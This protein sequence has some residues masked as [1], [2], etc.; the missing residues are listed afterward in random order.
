MKLTKA[1][2]R[3]LGNILA[4]GGTSFVS[5]GA[6]RVGSLRKSVV[7]ELERRG[8]VESMPIRID[9]WP[10]RVYYATAAG[11]IAFGPIVAVA[12]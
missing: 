7:A 10:D 12:S 8:L 2:R 1:Q 11:C 6:N 3:T 4:S 5:Q 9:G